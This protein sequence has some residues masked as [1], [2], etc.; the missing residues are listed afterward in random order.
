MTGLPSS[1]SAH[2]ESQWGSWETSSWDSS[3]PLPPRGCER[4]TLSYPRCIEDVCER[5]WRVPSTDM[6]GPSLPALG[7]GC[8]AAL[9]SSALGVS[10]AIATASPGTWMPFLP[11][12]FSDTRSAFPESKSPPASPAA[13]PSLH[14]YSSSLLRIFCLAQGTGWGLW[15]QQRDALQT[16]PAS[17]EPWLNGV[18]GYSRPERWQCYPTSFHPAGAEVR[19]LGA[20]CVGTV[21]PLCCL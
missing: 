20:S 12:P 9:L 8:G 15:H 7:Q 6:G 14:M 16:A 4:S 2:R 17:W 13:A 10:S 21:P 5:K 18:R 11:A 19:S 1:A 3:Q